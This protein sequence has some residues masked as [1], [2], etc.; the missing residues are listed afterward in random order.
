DYRSVRPTNRYGPHDN[1]HP[2]NTH[3][4]R[5]LLRRF[6]EG[7]QSHAPEV[8]VWGGGT[9]MREFVHVDDIGAGSIHVME[10]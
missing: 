9:P 10:L 2:D 7:A 8:V 4:S 6:H 5:A 3:V 1:F